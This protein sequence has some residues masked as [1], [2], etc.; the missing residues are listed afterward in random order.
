MDQV[1]T[2]DQFILT[3]TNEDVETPN[4]EYQMEIA[5]RFKENRKDL[6][7]G[8]KV[9]EIIMKKGKMKEKYHCLCLIEIISKNS[10]IK[11]HEELCKKKL[12]DTFMTLLKK[13][14]GKAGILSIKSRKAKDRYYKEKSEEKC[15]YLI[16]LWADTFMMYQ[17]KFKGVHDA[18]RQL[19]M[20][21]V[22]F[23]ER[24]P[25]E[26]MMMENLKGI[27]SPMFDFVE[28]ISGKERPKDLEEIS[29]E[30]EDPQ[31]VDVIPDDGIEPEVQAFDPNE[32]FSKYTMDSYDRTEF[33]VAK[34]T[35]MILE[36][37]SNNAEYITDLRTDIVH[38][39]YTTCRVS[40]ARIAKIIEVRSFA[41]KLNDLESLLEVLDF[42]DKKIELFRSKYQK[43]K[44]KEKKDKKKI[45]EEREKQ[46]DPQESHDKNE[47]YEDFDK[48][49]E[50]SEEEKQEIGGIDLLG[51]GLED[52][53]DKQPEQEQNSKKKKKPKKI[54]E[55]QNNQKKK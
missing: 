15:L 19:R 21:S 47:S 39:I 49:Q 14:R 31:Y 40:R 11:V 35:L 52:S 36:D 26:R 38:D 48:Y 6:V 17:D 16:Q 4:I 46:P 8:M 1:A 12:I 45:K 37:M 9:L 18:Y 50:E 29:K 25:N 10:S 24:D 5:S 44:E 20:E 27:D 23:P 3:V 7:I 43:L 51:L 28:Q 42:I 13:R 33:E 54:K 34:S 2:I 55:E 30:N 22:E 53:P 41:N 32:D